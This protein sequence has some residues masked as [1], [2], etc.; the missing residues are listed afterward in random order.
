[1]SSQEQ[2]VVPLGHVLLDEVVDGEVM[3]ESVLDS[4][5]REDGEQGRQADEAMSKEEMEVVDARSL[6]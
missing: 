5:N 2:E 1:M 4:S 6:W 3:D